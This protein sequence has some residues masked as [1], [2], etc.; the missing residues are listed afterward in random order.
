[1]QSWYTANKATEL[2]HFSVRTSWGSRARITICYF[3][4]T[5]YLQWVIVIPA[6][7]TP[8]RGSRACLWLEQGATA[9]VLGP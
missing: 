6:K 7:A 8:K 5:A 4:V 3:G 2:S 9:S 1:V